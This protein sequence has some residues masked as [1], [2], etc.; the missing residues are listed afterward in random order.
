MKFDPSRHH[1]RSTRLREYDYSGE[2]VYF[3][4]LCVERREHLFGDIVDGEMRLNTFGQIVAE[5]WEKSAKIRTNITLGEYIIMPDHFHGI[6]QINEQIKT[7]SSALPGEFKSPSHTIGAIIRGFKGAT[8]KRI[9]SYLFHGTGES[10][11]APTA[12]PESQFAPMPSSELKF[13]PT[14][15]ELNILA[16]FNPD[17]S[18]W[19]RNYYDRII[20]SR[21]QLE[22][23][24]NYIRNNPLKWEPDESVG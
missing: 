17:K 7:E 13:I 8:T 2:G 15:E 12:S 10:Q 11:F 21:H 24:I 23:T 4:T 1:R 14:R 19:Q 3:L 18:I 9:K 20:R 5:E 16:R 6:I 22:N